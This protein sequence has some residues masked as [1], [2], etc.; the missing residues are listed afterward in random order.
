VKPAVRRRLA[1]AAGYLAVAPRVVAV[2]ADAEVTPADSALPA[3]PA[4][5]DRLEE[6][7]RRYGLANPVDRLAKALATA[8]STASAG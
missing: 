7:A 2:R 5:P 6:L 4:H 1:E 8:A 3:V